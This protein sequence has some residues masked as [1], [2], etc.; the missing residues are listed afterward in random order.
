MYTLE[1]PNTKEQNYVLSSLNKSGW[2]GT[3]KAIGGKIHVFDAISTLKT[4]IDK[5]RKLDYYNCELL[6][7][8]LGNQ[9]ASLTK[10]NKGFLQMSPD[11]IIV[12]K[13]AFILN[14]LHTALPYDNKFDYL[15]SSLQQYAGYVAPEL[16]YLKH[17]P[18]KIHYEA[19]YYSI[20]LLCLDMLA[21][22][23]I[24]NIKGT[25]MYY[26]LKR[27]LREDARNRKFLFI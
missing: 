2:S 20:A 5:N 9:I 1:L 17:I 4:Y 27:C 15:I 13:N 23:N 26:F 6:A 24:E 3:W 19:I 25:K 12:F 16:K 8:Q 10:F 7:M 14:N 21:I 22:N 18:F 11:N